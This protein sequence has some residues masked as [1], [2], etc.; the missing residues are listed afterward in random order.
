MA[1]ARKPALAKPS[2]PASLTG[3]APLDA[4]TEASGKAAADAAKLMSEGADKLLAQVRE[5]QE[6]LRKAAEQSLAKSHEAYARIK[7]DAE[8]A[9][10]SVETSFSAA[11]SGLQSL[12]SKAFDAIKSQTE[13]NFDHVKAL[14]AAKDPQNLFELQSEFIRKQFESFASQSK[15]MGEH[16]QAIVMTSIEPLKAAMA[17]HTPA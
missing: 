13:V 7:A 12:N 4:V 1:I 3:A 17:R 14:L 10:G 16:M 8:A 2:V 5:A 15:E 6:G 9:T 11:R